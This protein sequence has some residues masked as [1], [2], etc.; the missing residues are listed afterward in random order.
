MWMRRH[1]GP[2]ETTLDL[3]QG[4]L[5]GMLDAVGD[6]ARS[7]S[8]EAL[9]AFILDRARPHGIESCRASS[10]PFARSSAFPVP[11]GDARQ[12]WNT[13]FP[14]LHLAPLFR[15]PLSRRRRCRERD[16]LVNRRRFRAAR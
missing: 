5:V 16:R 4:I 3:Y 11:R 14:V 13:P 1:R 8:A 7:Y 12:A 2:A 10:S 9:R 6:D 15:P